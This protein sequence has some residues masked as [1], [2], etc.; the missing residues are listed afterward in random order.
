MPD[1]SAE[2]ESTRTRLREQMPV[3]KKW[4]YLD[5]AAVAPLSGPAQ[6]AMGSWLEQAAEEG[7]TVWLDWAR[8]VN[9]TR[10][11]AAELIGADTDEIALVPHTTAGINLVAEG[12]DWQPGDNVVTLDDEFPSNI[13]PW[14]H[15]QRLGVE[16]RRVPTTHGRVDLDQLASHCDERTRVVSVS[17][18]GY[19][20]GCRRDLD[21][22]AG[23]AHRRD[24]LFFV[25]AI[26]GLGVFPLDVTKTPIDC[27][28]ADGHKW[29]LSPEG[30]GIAY[31]RRECLSRLT[32]TSVG[33][34]SVVHAADFSRIELDLKPTAARYEGGSHNMAGFLALGASLRMLLDAGVENIATAILEL[35]DRA[36]EELTQVG[37]VICSPRSADTSSGI[38][39]IELPSCDPVAVRRH[40]L[41]Q[42]VALACRA[43]RIRISA[44]AYNNEEDL[45]RLLNALRH[46]CQ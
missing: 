1:L 18:V 31:I 6:L 41:A 27:L 7:D 12:L 24:A 11:A 14:M 43:G 15:L 22:I 32:P 23:I 46:A 44:H 35:T 8:Q 13:Y 28:A 30:A 9:E 26:Q 3:T 21:A 45:T 25:D 2:I 29:L 4:A 42:G 5:H 40:C 10:A 37:A 36:A 39:S 33:W 16:T 17:W 19:A 34:N 20:N 38:L